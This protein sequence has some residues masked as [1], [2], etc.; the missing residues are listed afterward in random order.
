MSVYF[1]Y[2]TVHYVEISLLGLRLSHKGSIRP[3]SY[4][5]TQVNKAY[6]T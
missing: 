1:Y 5:Y 3:K 6:F 4:T 2:A